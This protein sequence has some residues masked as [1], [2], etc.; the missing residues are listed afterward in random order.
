MSSIDAR[1]VPLDPTSLDRLAERG[2][3]YAVVEPTEGR[4]A[5]VVRAVPRGFVEPEPSQSAI[6][7]EREVASERRHRIV[8]VFDEDAPDG[9]PVG[10][11]VS[12]V[13][14]LSVPG[15][16]LDMW[17]ISD[18]TV[19]GTHRRRGIARAM[20]EGE[21]RAAA[22][23]GLAMAGLTVS[24]GSIYG[25]YGFGAAVPAAHLEI[26]TVRAGW[27]GYQ[28]EADV[29]YVDRDVLAT[30]L[31]EVS[32]RARTERSGGI[33]G[34]RTRWRQ[35]AGVAPGVTDADRVRGVIARDADG[36]TMGAMAYRVTDSDDFADHTL[37]ISHLVAATPDAYAALWRFAL[38]HDLV[39]TVTA[40]FQTVDG[41]LRWLVADQRGIRQNESDNGW[42]RILDVPA[43]LEARTYAGEGTALAGTAGATLRVHDPLGIAEGTWRV[44]VEAGSVRVTPTELDPDVEL[45]VAELSAAYLGGASLVS[46]AD[47]GRVT[48]RQRA[49]AAMD[50]VLHTARAP[51][52]SFVY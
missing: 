39:R 20:V 8:A 37:A 6:S 21:L 1:R 43:A 36:Q 27:A 19:A 40:R 24:E 17:A 34:W 48:G 25:R 9:L 14:P 50:A 15:G 29:R 11:A 51:H 30:A 5:S 35:F 46:L 2:L 44:E 42:L 22:G 4:F 45:G 26:D 47:A 38:Q 52:L 28:P 12:W 32:E 7:V 3:E 16:E 33:P 13:T 49:L 23:A 18:V 41:A 31:G 10:T